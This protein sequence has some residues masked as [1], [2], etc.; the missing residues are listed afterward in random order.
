LAPEDAVLTFLRRLVFVASLIVVALL[1]AMFAYTNPQPVDVDIGIAR[2][3]GVSLATAFAVTLVLGWLFGLA[4]VGLALWRS[5]S[6]KRR[7]KNDLRSVEA[8][9]S[10]V[11]QGLA[12][13][14][15]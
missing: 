7:L 15:H 3:E 8:E 10:A 2:F 5:A 14:A 4:S 11:R 12:S 9:L 13:D 6:E 1:A